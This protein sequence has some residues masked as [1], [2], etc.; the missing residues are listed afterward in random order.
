[1]VKYFNSDE[2]LTKV[3]ENSAN[4]SYSLLLVL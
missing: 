3:W 2:Y 1:M 4:D